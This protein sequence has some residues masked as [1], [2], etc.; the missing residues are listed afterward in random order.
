M[1]GLVKPRIIGLT[2]HKQ[3]G[4]DT[5]FSLMEEVIPCRRIAFADPLRAEVLRVLG[6]VDPIPDDAPPM[7]KLMLEEELREI[8]AIPPGMEIAHPYTSRVRRIL[9]W[10]GTEYRRAQD[11]DYWLK[12]FLEAVRAA[13]DSLWVVTDVRFINEA[14]CIK[15]EG[16]ILWRIT[17]PSSDSSQ[18][19]H[20]SERYIDS[21]QPCI[22]LEN[23]WGLEELRS[24]VRMALRL[25]GLLE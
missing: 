20:V 22:V 15:R 10:W 11:A 12:R 18:D 1:L 6:G 13:P 24:N 7:L 9:Q 16:G 17:R 25:S 4:K 14:D 2:G 3:S 8:G 19:A 21:I 23:R 5:V